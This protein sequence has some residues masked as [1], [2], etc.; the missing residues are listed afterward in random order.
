M[1]IFSSLR[2]YATP[3]TVTSQRSFTQEEINAVSHC[4]VVASQYGN[5][6]CCHMK[7]GGMTFIPMSNDSTVGVGESVNLSNAS[8]LTLSK[9][10]ESDII[11]VKA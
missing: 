4:E 7:A 2:S 10:G 5:S 11:R 9:T 8:L 1:N 6:L 3:W